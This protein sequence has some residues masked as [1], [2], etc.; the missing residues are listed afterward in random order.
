MLL[1]LY[2]EDHRCKQARGQSEALVSSDVFCQFSPESDGSESLIRDANRTVIDPMTSGPPKPSRSST[3]GKTTRATRSLYWKGVIVKLSDSS[4]SWAERAEVFWRRCIAHNGRCMLSFFSKS[5]EQK[6]ST[7][8]SADQYPGFSTTFG[9][10][11]PGLLVALLVRV[12]GSPSSDRR[13]SC[14]RFHSSLLPHRTCSSFQPL[15]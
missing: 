1:L 10:L 2:L 3:V 12:F 4:S 14:L 9:F 15:L 13:F 8:V 5:R 7:F 11:F 6:D